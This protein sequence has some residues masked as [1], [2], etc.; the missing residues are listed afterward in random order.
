MDKAKWEK[1]ELRSIVPLEGAA[2]GNI[3]LA[4]EDKFNMKKK[5]S[6]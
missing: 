1:P 5:K 3:V 6:P 2:G 4:N